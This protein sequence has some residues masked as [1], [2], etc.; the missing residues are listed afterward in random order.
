MAKEKDETGKGQLGKPKD[1]ASV[2]RDLVPGMLDEDELNAKQDRL[3]IRRRK[4][5][6]IEDAEGRGLFEETEEEEE[7]PTDCED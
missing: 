5:P 7:P 4:G 3:R 1:L 6:D 2:P